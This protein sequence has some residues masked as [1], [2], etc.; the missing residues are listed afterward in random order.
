MPRENYDN[1]SETVGVAGGRRGG[2]GWGNQGTG[3]SPKPGEQGRVKVA[4]LA[5]VKLSPSHRA[6]AAAMCAGSPVCLVLV[7]KPGSWGG[8]EGRGDEGARGGGQRGSVS[9]PAQAN[10]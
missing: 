4:D 1:N 6:L 9:R 8:G 10:A 3:G 7:M 5:L 2:G